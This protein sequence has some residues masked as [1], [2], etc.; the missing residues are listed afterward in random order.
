MVSGLRFELLA[1]AGSARYARLWLTHGMVETPAF[2]PVAT[3]G[4]VRG[5]AAHELRS[6]GTEMIISNALHLLQRPGAEVLEEQGGLHAFMGWDG[7]L[8]TDSGGFQ[9]FSLA[10]ACRTPTTEGVEFHSPLDGKRWFLTPERMLA[11]QERMGVDIA[12]VLDECVAYSAP[13][14]RVRAAMR[15]TLAWA[16]RSLRARRAQSTA[17]FC[18]VQ[19]GTQGEL[20][21]ACARALADLDFDGYA[22]GGLSV[23]EPRPLL[24]EM[25]EISLREL[26]VERPR[27]LMGVGTPRELLEAVLRGVDLFDCVL[28]TRDARNGR[29]YTSAGVLRLR[30]AAHRNSSLPPDPDCACPVCRHHSRAYLHHLQRSGELL[31]ARLNTLHNLYYYQRL[32]RDLRGAIRQGRLREHAAA[33]RAAWESGAHG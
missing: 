23:G 32:L 15:R 20:R 7:P 8:L 22:V 12:M 31:G 27:Y 3:R 11:W 14:E 10:G 9:L 21:T 24:L 5:V 29:L 4:A 16:E 17:L 19:G 13:L 26:P 18:V 1:H 30:N 6:L 25:L 33:L 28:P 2:M